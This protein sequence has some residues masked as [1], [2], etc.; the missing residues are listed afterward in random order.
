[1]FYCKAIIFAVFSF[2]VFTSCKKHETLPELE[3]I[4]VIP[5]LP[6][7]YAYGSNAMVKLDSATIK[8]WGTTTSFVLSPYVCI[9]NILAQYATTYSKINVYNNNTFYGSLP[10]PTK[11][12]SKIVTSG[13]VFDYHFTLVD[14]AGLESVT[15]PHYTI[16]IP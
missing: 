1:M 3:P 11:T 15:S 8:P 7:V 12:F 4:K 10:K 14:T 16:T 13:Q 6:K 5:I 2:L 9:S